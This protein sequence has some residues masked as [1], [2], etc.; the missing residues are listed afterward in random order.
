MPNHPL[1]RFGLVNGLQIFD[2]TWALEAAQEA[3]RV[4]AKEPTCHFMVALKY[5]WDLKFFNKWIGDIAILMHERGINKDAVERQ[6]GDCE[7]TCG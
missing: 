7:V 6:W 5:P 3:V 1:F 4:R 2:F